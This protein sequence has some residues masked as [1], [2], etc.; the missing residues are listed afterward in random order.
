MEIGDG[1]LVENGERSSG[2]PRGARCPLVRYALA[3][4]VR[5]PHCNDHMKTEHRVRVRSNNEPL[6]SVH[7]PL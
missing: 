6:Q 4:S 1:D 2:E 7:E 3:T 5:G